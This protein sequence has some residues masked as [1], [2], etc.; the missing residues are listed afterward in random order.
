MTREACAALVKVPARLVSLQLSASDEEPF[1]AAVTPLP[2]SSTRKC[3]ERC[4][5]TASLG[6]HWSSY[7]RHRDVFGLYKRANER[8]PY[9]YKNEMR[10]TI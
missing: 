5:R 3:D 10:V 9:E 1:P 8:N 2:R 7:Q 6:P 4:W